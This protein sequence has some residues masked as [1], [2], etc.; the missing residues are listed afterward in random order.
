MIEKVIA[1]LCILS[2]FVSGDWVKLPQI[3]NTP[4]VTYKIQT[5]ASFSDLPSS[6]LLANSDVLN[7]VFSYDTP[8][9]SSVPTTEMTLIGETAQ[10]YQSNSKK[11]FPSTVTSKTIDFTH[12]ISDRVDNEEMVMEPVSLVHQRSDKKKVIYM[13]QTVA[14][15][16]LP[17]LPVEE[18]VKEIS[19]KNE[20]LDDA[21][22]DDGVTIVDEEDDLSSS[23]EATS[24]EEYYE[25]EEDP[26]PSSTTTEAPRKAPSRKPTPQRRV[27]QSAKAKKKL[28]NPLSFTH[29]LK[30]LQ[31]IQS[32]FATRTAKNI[33]DK[34]RMLREFRDNLLLTINQRIKTLWKTQSKPKKNKRSKRTL[35][36]GGEGWM[37]QGGGMEFPSAEG[38]LLSI[39]FLTFAVFLIKLVLVRRRVMIQLVECF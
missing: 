31:T 13:N 39:S 35:G 29:F 37:D 10:P 7:S 6:S 38:A 1:S 17:L 20:A 32:S 18:Q 5:V 22:D 8:K 4:K 14:M 12:K 21:E 11:Y 3:T 19:M 27:M 16:V 25:Y 34:I 23:E 30:F 36:G 15:R 24:Q 9:I 26:K 2:C 33:G 28:H